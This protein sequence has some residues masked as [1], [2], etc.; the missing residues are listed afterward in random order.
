MALALSDY[1]VRQEI[2]FEM[3]ARLSENTDTFLGHCDT[4]LRRTAFQLALCHTLGFGIPKNHGKAIDYLVKSGQP[5]SNLHDEISNIKQISGFGFTDLQ[6]RPAKF[7]DDGIIVIWDFVDEYRRKGLELSKVQEYHLR[8]LTD[9][10]SVLSDDSDVVRMLKGVL[11]KLYTLRGNFKQVEELRR[12]LLQTSINKYGD[13]GIETLHAKVD[14][15]N[16]LLETRQLTEAEDHLSA[17][18]SGMRRTLGKRHLA[19]LTAQAQWCETLSARGQHAETVPI[20]KEIFSELS[21]LLGAEH[22]EAITAMHNWASALGSSGDFSFSKTLHKCVLNHR[23]NN[24]GPRHEQTLNSKTSV[25]SALRRMGSYAEAEQ[26]HQSALDDFGIVQ[27]ASPS[28]ILDALQE[29]AIT[30][31][32]QGKLQEAE[33]LR[34]RAHRPVLE[35]QPEPGIEDDTV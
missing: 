29:F 10:K 27:G 9:M 35:L 25:A 28:T 24:L 23:I 20:Y 4:C 8:E 31:E 21:D 7:V 32:V 13:E 16:I 11:A 33:I 6:S 5:E 19:T 30:L 1:R 14:L 18:F 12:E 3:A 26:M 34:E 2:C 17:A 15:G 22:P